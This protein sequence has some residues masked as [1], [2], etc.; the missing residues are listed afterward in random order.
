MPIDP[1]ISNGLNTVYGL[2]HFPFSG[3]L[4]KEFETKIHKLQKTPTAP[5]TAESLAQIQTH[6]LMVSLA[7]EKTKNS[8]IATW[9][10]LSV[11]VAAVALAILAPMVMI[12][13]T[14]V[15]G[16]L[17]ILSSAKTIK[18]GIEKNKALTNL[19]RLT[20]N[21]LPQLAQSQENPFDLLFQKTGKTTTI[22]PSSPPTGKT[23]PVTRPTVQTTQTASVNQS[24]ST[25]FSPQLV[26]GILIKLFS[27]QAVRPTG[28]EIRQ[29]IPAMTR[30][31]ETS[32]PAEA[33]ESLNRI[34]SRQYP[35]NYQYI[36]NNILLN[37]LYFVT[38]ND[39]QDIEPSQTN[40]NHLIDESFDRYFELPDE[41]IRSANRLTQ[42]IRQNSPTAPQVLHYQ[43]LG[44]YKSI[45]EISLVR[46]TETHDVSVEMILQLCITGFNHFNIPANAPFINREIQQI[47]RVFFNEIIT[48]PPNARQNSQGDTPVPDAP[49]AQTDLLSTEDI[50]FEQRYAPELQAISARDAA[51]R[52]V[53]LPP[54]QAILAHHQIQ[55]E[56]EEIIP[57]L[58]SECQGRYDC[59]G[60]SCDAL[61]EAIDDAYLT[62][63]IICNL[64]HFAFRA[65]NINIEDFMNSGYIDFGNRVK[66]SLDQLIL[67]I[68]NHLD[69]L[70]P[71][72]HH[73]FPIQG[74]YQILYLFHQIY[75]NFLSQNNPDLDTIDQTLSTRFITEIAPHILVRDRRNLD[76]APLVTPLRE[77]AQAIL[78]EIQNRP[79]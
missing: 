58:V 32:N 23:N 54:L 66:N 39:L 36:T 79:T 50:P 4:K 78:E 77:A 13:L 20:L 65:N 49:I 27:T 12:P 48:N 68:T 72:S 22:P 37:A 75:R 16:V 64:F 31:L 11:T 71:G 43:I 41:A 7:S 57:T 53:L 61:N 30:F 42:S 25:R 56:T 47:S 14:A 60:A 24:T 70:Y 3:D 38:T 9:I 18:D 63:T 62:N 1:T 45:L 5:L 8:R 21:H 69:L 2:S 59:P 10:F 17:T 34:V 73:A 26:I 28:E 67:A 29:F 52:A 6:A 55:L 74:H 46:S 19:A 15:L 76:P 35:T 51:L 40:I 33:Q 44:V